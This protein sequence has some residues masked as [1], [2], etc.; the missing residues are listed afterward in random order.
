MSYRVEE[1]QTKEENGERDYC[2]CMA[3]YTKKQSFLVR[4]IVHEISKIKIFIYP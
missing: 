2:H 4:A 3:M 1:A